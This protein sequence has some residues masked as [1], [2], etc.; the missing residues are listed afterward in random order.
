MENENDF[1]SVLDLVYSLECQMSAYVE[2][3]KEVRPEDLGLDRRSGY[4]VY[5]D[6]TAIVVPKRDKGSLEYYGGFEYVDKSCRS[7]VGDWVIYS[8][9][10]DRVLGH[11]NTFFQEV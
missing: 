9:D 4:R 10:D 7:E 6:V 8:A 1:N 2:K 5:V 11:L 3:M